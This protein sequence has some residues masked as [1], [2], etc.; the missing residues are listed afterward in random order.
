MLPWGTFQFWVCL[1]LYQLNG[2]SGG[3]RISQGGAPIPRCV[4][5][6]GVSATYYLAKNSW[7]LHKNKENLAKGWPGPE[8]VYVEPPLG[9]I[10]S[11]RI[12]FHAPILELNLMVQWETVKKCSH[13]TKFSPSPIF[14]PLL[15]CVNGDGLNNG[16]NGW[17]THLHWNSISILINNFGLN[18]FVMCEHSLIWWR[19]N[20]ALIMSWRC[21]NFIIL[22]SDG[23]RISQTG[24]GRQPLIY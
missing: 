16:Q 24:W 6:A 5:E 3:S 2:N 15:H 7:K 9:S 20:A 22:S 10:V 14:V 23:S 11:F 1:P 12:L 17:R 13:V 8:F 18:H 21:Q 19:H 4:W